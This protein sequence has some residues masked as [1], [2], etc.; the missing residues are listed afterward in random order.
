MPAN[1]AVSYFRIDFGN[2]W[3]GGSPS[4]IS[5][6]TGPQY[7]SKPFLVHSTNKV[8]LRVLVFMLY[9]NTHKKAF[10]TSLPLI[11][12]L[13]H[14]LTGWNSVPFCLHG[15]SFWGAGSQAVHHLS[16]PSSNVL[17]YMDPW[18]DSVHPCIL[19]SSK[20]QCSV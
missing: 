11:Q 20:S 14:Y 15:S 12:T 5:W 4:S 8:H 18:F 3:P 9:F 2:S 16:V 17:D 7:L 1:W 19:I 13:P 6:S 10:L